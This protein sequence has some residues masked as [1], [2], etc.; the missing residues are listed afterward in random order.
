M[1]FKVSEIRKD[2]LHFRFET[3]YHLTS[4][5]MRLQE[6]YES[7]FENIKGKFFTTEQ[8][9]DTYAEKQNPNRVR[10]SYYTD[11]SGFN[12]PS[13]IVKK[14]IKLFKHDYTIKETMLL[15]TIVELTKNKDKYYVIGT[16]DSR[17]NIFGGKEIDAIR[18]EL[19]HAYYYLDR[20]YNYEMN[21]AVNEIL[22]KE[23]RQILTERLLE[24][25]YDESVI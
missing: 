15:N 17:K 22:L 20:E 12:V 1:K 13:N 8:F 21:R 24:L 14:F 19:A 6:F 11:W 5:F 23:H 16:Y 3:Q 18:H 4:T 25:G 9:M 7:P 2:V 10:F